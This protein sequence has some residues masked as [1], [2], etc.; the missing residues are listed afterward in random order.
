MLK[1]FVDYAFQNRSRY[2]PLYL[3]WTISRALALHACSHAAGSGPG[4]IGQ[5]L[6]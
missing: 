6:G 1:F 4:A 2:L 3:V 5:Y